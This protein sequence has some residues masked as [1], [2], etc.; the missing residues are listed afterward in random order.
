MSDVLLVGDVALLGADVVDVLAQEH[1]LVVAHTPSQDGLACVTDSRVR[2]YAVAADAEGLARLFDIY[3]FSAVVYVSGFV[4]AGAGMP[5]EQDLLQSLATSARQ[6]CVDKLVY[7]AGPAPAPAEGEGEERAGVAGTSCPALPGLTATALLR[8]RQQEELCR[9]LLSGSEVRLVVVRLPFLAL[10]APGRS[11]L[12]RLFEE[13]ASG[14]DVHLPFEAASPLDLLSQADLGSLLR[15]VVEEPQDASATYAAGSGYAR[16]WGELASAASSLAKDAHT[17]A[18]HVTCADELAAAPAPAVVSYPTSLRR[19]YGWIPFED[20]FEQLPALCEHFMQERA[21]QSRP[22]VLERVRAAFARMGFLKYVELVVLFVLVQLANNALGANIYYRFVDVR[23]LFVVLMG[24]MHGMRLGVLAAVL[25]SASTLASYAGQGTSLL[26][27]LMRVE[28][29]LPFA[30]YFLAGA[31][32]GYTTD[33]KDADAAFARQEYKLLYDKYQFLNE[34]YTKALENKRLY[35]R[36][37]LGFEDSFGRI[38]SVVQH[39]DDVM[40]QKLYAKALEA[41]EDVLRNRTVALYAVDGRSRFGRLMACSRPLRAHL[42]KSADLDAWPELKAEVAQGRVWRNVALEE[43]AP[44]LACGSLY[45]GRLQMVVCVWRA[46]PD[47]LDMRFA[48][49]LKVMCGLL[50]VSFR[51]AAE[52]A[53]LVRDEQCEPGTDV[54]RAAPFAEAVQAQ[55]DMAEKGL[56][57]YILLRFPGLSAAEAQERLVPS[58]R[59]TDRVGMRPDGCVWALLC[60]AKASDLGPVGARLTAAGLTFEP[61]GE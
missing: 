29:W 43:G 13:L 35:K 47:Q 49:L 17:P 53:S 37:I 11:M 48:N 4:D 40:P 9:C 23:L 28:M 27:I 1:R 19:A 12:A 15:S 44:A 54:M 6:A 60:Q 39:L 52:H 26:A 30:L 38:F 3:S 18:A 42:P 31:I 21:E 2:A 34:V 7:L 8:A 51:R 61:V 55:R 41:L 46:E 33:K 32:C 56:A 14:R 20:A 16:T 24:V 36:Q 59:V 45:G 10:A 5:D 57:D 22:S 50:E 25:A 58:L